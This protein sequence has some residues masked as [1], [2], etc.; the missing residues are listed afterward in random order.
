MKTREK[1]N[2]H[3]YIKNLFFPPLQCN[4]I[5]PNFPSKSRQPNISEDITIEILS[6]LP[7]KSLLRFKSICKRWN[8]LISDSKF[9]FSCTRHQ[10][11]IK[12][13]F[14]LYA[15]DEVEE[16][17]EVSLRQLP[18]PMEDML[19]L[20]Q[21][22][23]SCNGL[24]LVSYSFYLYLWNPSTNQCRKVL[25]LLNS[26]PGDR[27]SSRVYDIS[28]LCYDSFADDY[29]AVMVFGQVALVVSLKTKY[30]YRIEFPYGGELKSGPVVDERL[31]WLVAHTEI[32]CFDPWTE[33]FVEVPTPRARNRI[34]GL[35]VLKEC[36]CMVQCFDYEIEVLVMKEY[37]VGESWT[38]LFN[39]FDN[40][41]GQTHEM[42][43]FCYTKHGEILMAMDEKQTLVYNPKEDS[44]RVIQILNDDYY[45][46]F[47]YEESL[48]SPSHYG[49]EGDWEEGRPEEVLDL[50]SE[51]GWDCDCDRCCGWFK[52]DI[53]DDH[54]INWEEEDMIDD[55]E[56]EF[57]RTRKTR[58]RN[59]I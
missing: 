48:V 26:S 30:W 18:K 12:S 2:G 5:R 50:I 54:Y 34:L 23:G 17:G 25:K 33:Q 24:L 9:K 11:I 59:R 28:G 35:G 45:Y 37:G 55:C 29:K 1:K 40:V 21:I 20:L 14:Y 6:R 47:A 39:L 52:R 13:N 44:H 3:S 43:S 19:G 32:V 16:E 31:H 7:V 4:L 38:I 41:L 51:L 46:V 27:V 15:I 22:L 36:L 57:F 8:S 42:V 58:N 56:E 49:D 10:L 53:E